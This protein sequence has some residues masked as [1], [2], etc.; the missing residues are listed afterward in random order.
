[1]G[2]RLGFITALPSDIVIE[3]FVHLSQ[4]DSLTCMAVCRDWYSIVP[5]YAQDLWKELR[6]SERDA[7]SNH[8]RRYQCLGSHVK[9]VIV[10]PT[11]KS[12]RVDEKVLHAIM[13]KL[14]QWGCTEI[15]SFVHL[16]LCI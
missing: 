9:T 8:Q 15:K 1:M 10:K 13:I 2:K 14:L 4:Q 16:L 7:S 3:I 6:L 12:K 11:R 5:Q